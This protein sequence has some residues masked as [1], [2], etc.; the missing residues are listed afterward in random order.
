M[1]LSDQM[2]RNMTPREMTA[3]QQR[4]S[5]EQLGQITATAARWS[6]RVAAQIHAVAVRPARHGHQLT[7]FRKAGPARCRAPHRA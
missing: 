3:S 1:Y 4:E 5:D 7:A 6:Q 2:L